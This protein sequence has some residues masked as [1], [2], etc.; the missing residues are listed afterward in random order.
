MNKNKKN[1]FVY[2][3]FWSAIII[4]AAEC[5]VLSG[6]IWVCIL[7]LGLVSYSLLLVQEVYTL[8]IL[9]EICLYYYIY[10]ISCKNMSHLH[11]IF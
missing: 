2:S 6:I 10:L 11:I 8:Y 4:L 9:Y 5:C 7:S 3:L 1:A